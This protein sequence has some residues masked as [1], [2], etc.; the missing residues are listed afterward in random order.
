LAAKE[1]PYVYQVLLILTDGCI[2]DI[3]ETINEIINAEKL[4]ISIIIIGVG[5]ED[6]TNM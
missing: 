4:P 5:K 3:E 6:F 1:N 2:H